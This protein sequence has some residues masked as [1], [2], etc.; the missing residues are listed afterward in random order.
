M[1]NSF[2]DH[3]ET[4]WTVTVSMWVM[5]MWN[6][7]FLQ[8]EYFIEKFA[9]Q[10]WKKKYWQR[11]GLFIANESVLHVAR[12]GDYWIFVLSL[13][14]PSPHLCRFNLL[15]SAVCVCER[16]WEFWP[17]LSLYLSFLGKVFLTFLPQTS[18]LGGE[19]GNSEWGPRKNKFS[20][21]PYER[22]AFILKLL[23]MDFPRIQSLCFPLL[24][25]NTLGL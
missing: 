14:F 25:K 13:I 18:E 17:F 4:D 23:S 5:L 21:W 7:T 9:R 11:F 12:G 3:D 10:N 8:S 6:N 22:G 1:V 2:V 19:G 16:V 15:A 24:N 20:E